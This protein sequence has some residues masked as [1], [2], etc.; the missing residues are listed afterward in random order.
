M[1][2][3]PRNGW[4]EIL[5]VDFEGL[6]S[7]IQDIPVECM[8]AFTEGLRNNTPV[9]LHFDEE[10]SVFSVVID[11]NTTKIIAES[12]YGSEEYTYPLSVLTLAKEVLAD[13][14]A[15]FTEWVEWPEEYAYFEDDEQAK[16]LTFF[17]ERKAMLET[18]LEAFRTEI[19]RK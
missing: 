12:V 3:K 17:E 18:L 13:M 19:N 16:K 8:Q 11:E 7:Y 1:F 15:Y 5:I 14:E 9:K 2:E 4:T 10:G 6:G